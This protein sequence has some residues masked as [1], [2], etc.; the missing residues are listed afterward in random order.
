MV[1]RQQLYQVEKQGLNLDEYDPTVKENPCYIKN[2]V[3]ICS[4]QYVQIACD[5]GL[6]G[7]AAVECLLAKLRNET[8]EWSRLE[9]G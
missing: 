8:H 6:H 9:T 1:Q 3:V 5:I 2:I 7:S 4:A